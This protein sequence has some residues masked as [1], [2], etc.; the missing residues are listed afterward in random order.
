MITRYY[1]VWK[2]KSAW[3]TLKLLMLLKMNEE[4]IVSASLPAGCSHPV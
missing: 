2:D 4:W 1:W 3:P